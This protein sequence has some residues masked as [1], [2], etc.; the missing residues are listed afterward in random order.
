MTKNE[1]YSVLT[2]EGVDRGYEVIAEYRV[3]NGAI[4]IDLVW[5]KRRPNMPEHQDRSNPEYWHLVAGFEIEGC[6][7][8]MPTE[9]RPETEFTRH[10][11]N[12]QQLQQLAL[13]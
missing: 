1:I 11:G 4:K 8:P 12:F 2:T 13:E 3:N 6:N 10:L 5:V 7:V 9:W